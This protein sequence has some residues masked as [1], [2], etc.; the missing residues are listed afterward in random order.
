[1]QM[2]FSTTMRP[3][4][5]QI[6]SPRMIQSMEI[7][8]LA[9]MALQKRIEHELEENPFLELREPGAEEEG[10]PNEPELGAVVETPEQPA[11]EAQEQEKPEPELVIDAQSG[12]KDFE[13]IEAL[14]AISE[15]WA[16]HFN[17]ES[18]PS[19]NR[20][21]EEMDKKHDAMAN[22]A[23]RPQSLQ[24]YLEEQL[25]Y[26]DIDPPTRALVDFLISHIDDRGYLGYFDEDKHTYF[27]YT[28]EEL[29]AE[30]G[31]DVTVEQLSAALEFVQQ[32]DPI[33]VGARDTKEC[34]ML[35]LARE[36]PHRD[37]VCALIQHHLED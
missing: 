23:A 13:R 34:L 25:P 16:D 24:D 26:L 33:G 20:I 7:L 1:M 32:L 12:E 31:G 22:M 15:D 30:I 4:M 28:L 8:Q 10:Y 27:S 2:N 18:R 19:A 11:V 29:A 14:E 5:S 17:E 6:I 35:Q 36:T 21:S 3:E 37:V 9:V